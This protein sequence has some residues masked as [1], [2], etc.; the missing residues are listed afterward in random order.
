[1]HGVRFYNNNNIIII[2]LLGVLFLF[3]GGDDVESW[4]GVFVSGLGELL[5]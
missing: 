4:N 3:F 5:L 1:M 2:L